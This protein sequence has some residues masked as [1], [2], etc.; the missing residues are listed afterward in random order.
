MSRRSISVGAGRDGGDGLLARTGHM[1]DAGVVG[2]AGDALARVGGRLT[3][4]AHVERW[5]EGQAKLI[6][7]TQA[8]DRRDSAGA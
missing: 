2:V 3:T 4:A 1:G 7:A 6:R 8:D 5:A